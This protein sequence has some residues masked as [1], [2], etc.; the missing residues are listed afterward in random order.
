MTGWILVD[1]VDYDWWT[2]I[3]AKTG[4]RIVRANYVSEFS[5]NDAIEFLDMT[6][7]WQAVREAD[8]DVGNTAR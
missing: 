7:V 1:T 8:L 6:D 4:Q 2:I 5:A 3:E